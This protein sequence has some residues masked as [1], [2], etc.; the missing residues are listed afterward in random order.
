LETVPRR[1]ASPSG[2]TRMTARHHRQCPSSSNSAGRR[3]EGR[4][5]PLL[6]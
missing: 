2:W 1:A 4:P 3:T 5:P 6:A